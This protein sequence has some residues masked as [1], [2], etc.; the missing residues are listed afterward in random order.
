MVVR[1][2]VADFFA[3]AAPRALHVF[4]AS[5]AERMAQVATGLLAEK[6]DREDSIKI[7]VDMVEALWLTAS[8]GVPVEMHPELFDGF[9]ELQPHEEGLSDPFDIHAV[10]SLLTLK[11]ATQC[12]LGEGRSA[13]HR[14]AHI[15]LT[16]MDQMARNS[17]TPRAF[18]EEI[19]V[20]SERARSLRGNFY[21]INIS[22]LRERDRAVSRSRLTDLLARIR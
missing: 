11:Y 18:E 9:P 17:T 7:C 19:A 10:Y 21:E 22:S 20:Q 16:A 12:A 3:N 4:V 6:G 8:G 1:D 15:A 13:A 5:C 14:C 2:E